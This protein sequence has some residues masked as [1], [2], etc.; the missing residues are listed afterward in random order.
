MIKLIRHSTRRASSRNHLAKRVAYLE[1][2][3]HRNHKV[4]EILCA[5][6]Y[7]CGN[8]SN[9]F[10]HEVLLINALYQDSHNGRRGRPGHRLFEEI[11]YS[12]PKGVWLDE[13]ERRIIE[14]AI[15]RMVALNT[16][17][18]TAWHMDTVTGRADMHLLLAARTRTTPPASSLWSRFSGST[19]IFVEFDLCDEKIVNFLNSMRPQLHLKSASQLRHAKYASKPLAAELAQFAKGPVTV[20]SLPSLVTLAGHTVVSRTEK[21]ISLIFKGRSR[22]RRYNSRNLVEDIVKEALKQELKPF[23]GIVLTPDSELNYE[24]RNEF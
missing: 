7:R 6:N 5:R 1:D 9:D 3:K 12:S 4:K 16:A 18:R 24:G 10:I 21:T 17:C 2:R 19:H 23:S 14:S 11:V 20:D 15:V 13:S 22:P 8:S